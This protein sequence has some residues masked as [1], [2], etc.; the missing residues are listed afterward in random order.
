MNNKFIKT[1]AKVF[2][3]IL[4]SSCTIKERE[5]KSEH[6]ELN[7]KHE[8]R[9][10]N[11][12][13]TTSEH[14]SASYFL[15]MCSYS[16]GKSEKTDVRFYFNNCKGEFQ[17]QELPLSKIRIKIDSLVAEPF[18]IF[19]IGGMT[20]STKLRCYELDYEWMV[21]SATIYCKENDFQPEININDLR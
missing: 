3:L 19:D 9:K 2:I 15:I 11:V 8:L 6:P 14:S 5:E 7:V 21:S 17:F 4:L 13:T 16:S 1:F 10:F 18:I 20:K 12:K